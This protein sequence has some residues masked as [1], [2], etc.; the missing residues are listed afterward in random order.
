MHGGGEMRAA[1]KVI[2]FFI[3]SATCMIAWCDEQSAWTQCYTF[4]TDAGSPCS[5]KHHQSESA[6]ITVKKV[7]DEN[8]T[9]LTVSNSTIHKRIPFTQLIFSWNALR[10]TQGFFRFFVRTYD[11]TSKRWSVWHKMTEWGK[12]RQRSFSDKTKDKKT[13]YNF[14]HLDLAHDATIF[15]IKVDAVDE[16]DIKDIKMISVCVSRLKD[17]NGE[18]A[19]H[20]S[21]HIRSVNIR[22]IPRQSQMILD[23]P[24]NKTLCSP[25]ATSMLVAYL[26]KKRISTTQFAD[27]SYDGG[28]KAYGNWPFNTA[29]AFELCENNFFFS[30]MR[31][32]SFAALHQLLCAQIPVVVSVRGRMKNAPQSYPGGHLLL[33]VGYDAHKK[34]VICHDPA[35]PNNAKV[36]TRYCLSDFLKAWERSYRLAYAAIKRDV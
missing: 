5:A 25:T 11:D 22:G 23:H 12:D 10:P 31:L 29:H 13:A 33:V 27:L 17:M 16:S 20:I 32:Q 30:A 8:A 9:T 3:M 28:L 1:K 2:I 24:D 6:V 15:E 4:F 7:M 19:Q 34:N 18:H 35:Q 14:A 21:S 26:L 36:L